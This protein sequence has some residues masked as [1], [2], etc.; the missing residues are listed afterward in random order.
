MPAVAVTAATSASRPCSR[1]LSPSAA[2]GSGTVLRAQDRRGARGRVPEL[3][4]EVGRAVR[5]VH[6]NA[7]EHVAVL[8]AG[9]SLVGGGGGEIAGPLHRLD[10][11]LV[12]GTRRVAEEIDGQPEVLL[13]LG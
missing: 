6:P 8:W 10:H 2:T 13:Q 5:A 4:E 11:V 1:P 3:G 9:V 12:V 7:A